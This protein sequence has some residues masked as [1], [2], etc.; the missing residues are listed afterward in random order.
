[1]PVQGLQHEAVPA[2]GA[3]DIG[4]VQ[5]MIAIA[6]HKTRA[7][8]HRRLGVTGEKG[9]PGG[10]VIVDSRACESAYRSAVV[11]LLAGRPALACAA[12]P[13]PARSG[14]TGDTAHVSAT[15]AAIPL[16]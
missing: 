3:D 2:Q 8:G 13:A 6:L 7:R 14:A 16:A 5:R 1:M 15:G 4:G 9:N 10:A 11:G 12:A